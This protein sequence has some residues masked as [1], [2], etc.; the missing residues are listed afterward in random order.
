MRAS[1]GI[2]P[3]VCANEQ[4]CSLNTWVQ[5]EMSLEGRLGHTKKGLNQ[6][7]IL[8]LSSFGTFD[9]CLT[10]DH[11]LLGDNFGSGLN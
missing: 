5:G 2:Y 3:C 4:V 8:L 9:N 11:R 10:S 6:P 1:A 7:K